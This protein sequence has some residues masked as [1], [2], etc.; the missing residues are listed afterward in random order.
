MLSDKDLRYAVE[1]APGWSF[2]SMD[3]SLFS[4]PPVPIGYPVYIADPPQYVLDALA[5]ELVRQLQNK[6]YVTRHSPDRYG[7]EWVIHLQP[8]KVVD[9]EVIEKHGC[10]S[11]AQKL[12]PG[13]SKRGPDDT[14]NTIKCVVDFHKQNPEVFK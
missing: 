6:V 7:K 2:N 5:A 1:I 14:L 4:G 13:I 3:A 12:A 11:Y 8:F 10:T 9:I